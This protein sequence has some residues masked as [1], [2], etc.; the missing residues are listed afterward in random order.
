MLHGGNENL[1]A[2]LHYEICHADRAM[3]PIRDKLTVTYIFF[4]SFFF[5]K[6]KTK[7]N[8]FYPSSTCFNVATATDDAIL[9][10]PSTPMHS[11]VYFR[12]GFISIR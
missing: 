4:F 12:T 5:K 2:I 9:N 7:K 1:A 3:G 6:K 10:L 8:F 11:R